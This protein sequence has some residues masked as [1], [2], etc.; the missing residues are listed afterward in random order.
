MGEKELSVVNSIFVSVPSLDDS[1]IVPTVVNCLSESS[2][3][4]EIHIGIAYS[5]IFNSKKKV[6]KL[7]SELEKYPNV[8][9][10][11]QNF[12]NHTGV[13]FGR[14]AAHSLYNGEDYFLQID[15]HTL[16]TPSWDKKIIV[17]YSDAVKEYGERVALTGYL[18]KYRYNGVGM[19]NRKPNDTHRIMKAAFSRD[20]KSFSARHEGCSVCK[21]WEMLPFW[22]NE[23]LTEEDVQRRYIKADKVSAGFIFS[24]SKFAESYKDY[25]PF[26]YRFF[27]EEIVMSIEMVQRGYKL[28]QPT[29]SGLMYHLY[30]SDINEYGGARENIGDPI[31]EKHKNSIQSIIY[32]YFINNKES[33]SN[34]EQYANIDIQSLVEKWGIE[35]VR[36]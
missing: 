9:I 5:V 19:D 20:D 35:N 34:Y 4:N 32:S 22:D 1:E 6:N 36:K 17:E 29:I 10:K 18:P 26:V 31:I 3:E 11:S 24:D 16:F 30:Y 2:G 21:T 13:G 25:F 27:E 8:Q 23:D 12:N 7:R 14:L 28:I 33:V 15:S